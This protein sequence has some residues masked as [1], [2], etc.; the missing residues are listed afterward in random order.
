MIYRL[1][2]AFFRIFFAVLYRWKV[3]GLENIPDTGPVVLCSNHISNL[4][5]MLVAAPLARKN[6]LYG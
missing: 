3:I 4:D 2:R 6:P 1:I 5:P